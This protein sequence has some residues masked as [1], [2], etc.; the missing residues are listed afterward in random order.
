MILDK[1]KLYHFTGIGG[2]G[3]S[4]M[5]EAMHKWGFRVQGSD[6]S[7]GDNIASLRKSGIK[8]FIG[9]SASNAEGADFVVY[10]SAVP[11]DNVELNLGV[12]LVPRAEMLAALMSTKKSVAVAGTHGKTTTTSFVGT[13]LDFGELDPFIIDGGIMNYYGAHNRIGSGGW[14]VVEACEAYGNIR[15][16]SPTISVITNIDPEHLDYYKTV[17]NL[18]EEFERLAART[19]DMVVLCN[20]HPVTREMAKKLKNAV[21]YGID[22]PADLT[23]SN[24]RIADDGAHF[25]SNVMKGLRIPLYGRHNVQ[26][27]LAA[28]AVGRS[29]DMPEDKMR[30]SLENFTGTKHRFSR[31]GEVGGVRIFDDYGHHP[32]EISATLSLAREIAKGGGIFAVFEPHRYSRLTDL[33]DDYPKALSLADRVVIMPVYAA[34]ESAEG[35]KSRN[36]LLVAM[37]E[38]FAADTMDDVARI[39]VNM[40]HPGDM[41]VSFS[42]GKL[43]NEIYKLLALLQYHK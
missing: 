22:G 12:P 31:V 10:S 36:D 18:H 35:M 38:A 30:A 4:S 27:A 33:F 3:M 23:A 13:M 20:D 1:G 7:E 26:N 28:I 29:L 16:F 39:I 41:V 19:S 21:T 6:A 11:L 9:H 8:T 14:M 2:I 40:A 43:K 17:E 5:A 25:D 34:R 42:A 32:A 37:P 24:I 15:Y